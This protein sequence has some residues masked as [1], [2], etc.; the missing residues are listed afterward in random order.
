M[1]GQTQDN[2]RQQWGW[3]RHAVLIVAGCMIGA[4]AY[5]LYLVPN[6]IAPGGLTGIA[7]VLHYAFGLPVG[8]SSL[9]MNVPLFI[10]GY[11]RMGGMFAFRT[12]VATVLFSLLIDLFRL[13]PVTSDPLLAS[14]FGGVLL[15]VGL[16]LI[17]RGGATTGGTDLLARLVHR[18]FS[19]LSMGV[20]LLVFDI[21]VI[22]LAGFTMSSSHAMYSMISVFI[23]TKVLDTVL[24][25]LGTDKACYIIT[26]C[27]DTIVQRLL[28][29]VGR[30]VTKLKGTGAYSNKQVDL[31]LCVVGRT[32]LMRVKALVNQED[33]NAFVFITDTHETLGEGFGKL[34]GNDE[35]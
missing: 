26:T 19:S 4:I 33:P 9:V 27:S 34:A 25:G 31:L 21:A 11:R 32:E 7:T 14:V 35:L 30:G 6:G 1:Q 5:P 22:L 12:L 17:L 18:R 20:F 8:I 10:L 15:G 3:I 13:D 16:G 28:Q 23:I 2:E 24:A 29:E